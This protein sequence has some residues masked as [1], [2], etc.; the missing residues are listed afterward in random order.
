M[1]QQLIT[2][3]NKNAYPAPVSL[4]PSIALRLLVAI[5]SPKWTASAAKLAEMRR[6]G[7]KSLVYEELITQNGCDRNFSSILFSL[8]CTMGI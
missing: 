7:R 1:K 8:V 2:D 6:K 5:F 3:N 4:T